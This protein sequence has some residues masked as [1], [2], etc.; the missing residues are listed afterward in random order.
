VSPETIKNCWNKVE[1]LP[2]KL[3]VPV[4]SGADK[5]VWNEI[6]ELLA[7]LGDGYD[8]LLISQKNYGRRHQLNQMKTMQSL[9]LL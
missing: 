2:I 4:R 9:L 1:I 6:A 7:S 5:P 8:L 3:Q